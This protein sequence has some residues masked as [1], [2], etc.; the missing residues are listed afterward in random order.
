MTKVVHQHQVEKQAE[1]RF[2][3]EVKQ[4]KREVEELQRRVASL[5][6]LAEVVKERKQLEQ[7]NA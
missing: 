1:S 5:E 3:K 7:I 6:Q 2:G 4:L